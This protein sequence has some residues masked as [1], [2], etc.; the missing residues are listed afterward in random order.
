MLEVVEFSLGLLAAVLSAAGVVAVLVGFGVVALEYAQGLRGQRSFP[1]FQTA[2]RQ[3]GYGLVLA[4]E[5]FVGADLLQ[6]VARPS[7][8]ELILLAI[9]VV[10]RTIIS[11]SLDYELRQ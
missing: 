11:L 10:L 7:L 2:R 8:D 9:L 6:I 4:L 1:S 5:L 3:L